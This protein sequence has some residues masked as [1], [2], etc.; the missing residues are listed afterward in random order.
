MP[1]TVTKTVYT[2]QELLDLH[3]AGKVKEKAIDKARQWLRDANTEGEWYEWVFE[4]WTERA[5]ADRFCRCQNQLYRLLVSR[6]RGQLHGHHR[7]C[8]AG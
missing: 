6:R 8:Q 4:T 2:F 5:G 1:R 3:K 7:H